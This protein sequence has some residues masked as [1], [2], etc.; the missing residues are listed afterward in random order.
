MEISLCDEMN[1]GTPRGQ[2]QLMLSG[3][4]DLAVWKLK[5][6][7]GQWLRLRHCYC[8]ANCQKPR[9][10]QHSRTVLTPSPSR[11]A[12]WQ[13]TGKASRVYRQ[14]S[15]ADRARPDAQR[16]SGQG[17]RG[18]TSRAALSDQKRCG[19]DLRAGQGRAGHMHP[20]CGVQCRRYEVGV[21]R[22]PRTAP[23]ERRHPMMPASP[24][25]RSP[26]LAK[27][28]AASAP[29]ASPMINRGSQGCERFDE[30]KEP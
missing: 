21:G 6:L 18:A 7:S 23:A 16:A 5:M 13:D 28:K 17:R 24:R 1:G 8:V 3:R 14:H 29:C 12:L 26:S 4:G 27:G 19:R 15:R 2:A 11:L 20:A 30:G 25:R 9:T 10:R 22:L